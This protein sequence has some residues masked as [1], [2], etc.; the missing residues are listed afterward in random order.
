MAHGQLYLAWTAAPASGVIPFDAGT[1]AI[2]GTDA[3][4][5][6]QAPKFKIE[7][8][9]GGFA[10][11]SL[12]I[13]NP[14]FGLLTPGRLF[15]AWISYDTGAGIVPIFFGRLV[16]IPS[17]LFAEAIDI[18]LIAKP[19]DYIYQKQQAAKPL[20]VVPGYDPL[21]IA[22]E[23]RDDPDTI[24]E[25]WSL[26]YHVDRI[27]LAVN[28]SDI[29][30][31][32]DG[33]I[34]FGTDRPVDY[35]SVSFEIGQ[36]PLTS[37][38]VRA[39]VSW[40]Q[41]DRDYVNIGQQVFSSYTGDGIISDWPKAG[42]D[43]GQGWSC[44]TS[45]AVDSYGV[46]WTLTPNFHFS[47]QNT[48][49][50]HMTGDTMSIEEDSSIPLFAGP[51]ASAYVTYFNQMGLIVPFSVDSEGN[52]DP[53]NRPA[54]TKWTRTYVPLW[55]V[56]TTLLLRY[57][58]DRQRT[59][60]LEFILNASTQPVIEDPTVQ[61]VTEEI[62]VQSADAGDPILNLLDWDSVAG[63]PVELGQL[64]FPDNPVLP[65]QTST[66]IAV[67]AGTAG[68]VEPTFSNI[69]GATTVDG[70]VTWASLGSS[71]P[72][73]SA[74]DWTQY[75]VYPR[76]QIML[77]RNPIYLPRSILGAPGLVQFPQVGVPVSMYQLIQDDVTKSFQ[78]C[79]LSGITAVASFNGGGWSVVDTVNPDASLAFSST[80]GAL[81]IDGTVQWRCIGTQLPSGLNYYICTGFTSGASLGESDQ[82]PPNWNPTIGAITVDGTVEWTSVGLADLPIGG[83]PGHTIRRSYFPTDRG[84]QSIQYLISKARARLRY[85]ARCVTIKFTCRFDDALDVTCRKNA[86]LIDPRL[87]GGQ[88]AGKITGYTLELNGG[89]GEF[90]AT[91]TMGCS[92]GFGET[93]TYSL[94]TADYVDPGYFDEG[95]VQQYVGGFQLVSHEADIAY[96]PPLDAPNDD[97]LVFPLTKDQVVLSSATY[98]S[99]T[100]QTNAI[101]TAL[102]FAYKAAN[103][104]ALPPGPYSINQAE[105]GFLA[106]VNSVQ[107]L[108]LKAPIW[109]ELIL[110]PL[111]NGPFV[112]QYDLDV[113]PLSI[114]QTI[115]LEA[116][117]VG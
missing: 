37:V 115:N 64:I 85:R 10:T 19:T 82:I 53:T 22:F 74:P 76:G 104:P 99:L 31:G 63:L 87:P 78:I 68:T 54:I 56:G 48:A 9:E 28:T 18:Q 14:R 11:A 30:I 93:I 110:K 52:P 36:P 5:I 112:S 109:Y 39:D 2:R 33:T 23:K 117:S 47:F 80:W 16:G 34:T 55:S 100:D 50:T 70:T 114:P 98:G 38:G 43:L 62:T 41:Q 1:M 13:K 46:Q 44:A 84:Q 32:E 102:L 12:T 92:V 66:Q 103:P 81:T 96:S 35:D 71:Q 6:E 57:D 72:A 94:G 113:T 58:A 29:L 69:A 27:T 51:T 45:V 4:A 20:K 60:R 40:R 108:L 79:V 83:W 91:V 3:I 105:L 111:R 21:F 24:L 97:G 95:E 116:P 77:P 49:K 73:A 90:F 75:T 67:V 26:A 25:G 106:S 59:D 65:G 86:I 8:A 15:W 88:A 101:S 61:Q 17:N 42:Q 107:N 89:T 7:Q